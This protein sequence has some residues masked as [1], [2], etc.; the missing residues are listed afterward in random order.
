MARSVL[1][2]D[3]HEVV[4]RNVRLFFERFPEFVV[5]GE[6]ANGVEAIERAQ[7]LSPE[8][9]VLD[10]AMPEM[11]GLEAAGALRYMMPEVPLF[12]L[13]GHY[14][15]ELELAA[16]ASG[17]CAVF[18]KHG[19]LHAMI[20]RARAELKIDEAAQPKDSSDEAD[21]ADE[22]DDGEHQAKF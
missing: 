11:N 4:R 3:D 21:E 13:T 6:A 22:N 16:R 8:L 1:I 17:I 7:E 5:C 19:D 18:A 20:R 14:T 10:M 12:L 15:R 9:I 2:V